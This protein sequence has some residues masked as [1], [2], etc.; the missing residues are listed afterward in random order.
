[1]RNATPAV[2]FLACIVAPMALAQTRE[3]A[4]AI[5]SAPAAT[6]RP[7]SP[8]GRAMANFTS[9]LREASLQAQQAQAE[10]HEKSGSSTKP[11]ASPAGQGEPLVSRSNQGRAP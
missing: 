8:V 1:M 3:H 4:S 2:A 9:L 11:A 10:R 6:A 7:V 5:T